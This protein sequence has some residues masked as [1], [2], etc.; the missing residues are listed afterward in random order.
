MRAFLLL[1]FLFILN[2]SFDNK[3]GIW[4]NSNQTTEGKKDDNLSQFKTLSSLKDTFDKNL[5]INKNF[6]FPVFTN[7]ESTNWKEIYYRKSNNL[8]NFAYEE[9]NELILKS[10]K[11]TNKKANNKILSENNNII[12]NDKRGNIIIYSKSQNKILQKFNFYKKRFKNVE[13]NLNLIVE[14]NIIFVS[15]NLGYLYAYDY[16]K[17]KVIWAKDYKVPFRSNLKLSNNGTCKS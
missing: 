4:K 7:V 17:D 5:T 16:K 12:I 10:G 6:K 8:P 9:K 3:S 2:C 14:K 1:I 15:D 11:I 13:K